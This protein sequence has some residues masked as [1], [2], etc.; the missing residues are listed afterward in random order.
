[1]GITSVSLWS[2]EQELDEGHFRNRDVHHWLR[3]LGHGPGSDTHG[4]CQGCGCATTCLAGAFFDATVDTV[5]REL[6][7]AGLLRKPGER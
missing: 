7:R 5:L 4:C 6:N 2:E 1:M 3:A